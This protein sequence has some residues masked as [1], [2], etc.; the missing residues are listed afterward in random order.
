MVLADL[1]RRLSS[2]LRNLSNA[3][4]IN[5]QVLNEA[6]GEICRALLEA[7]VNVRLVKQLRENV[8]QAINLEETAV[9]LNK[10][11]LIQSAVV[12]E[13]VRLIDPEVKAWQPVKNK[14]NIVMFVG[15]QGSGKTTT[16][17][18]Y[19][20]HFMRRGWKTALVC[21]DT[22][23]AGAFDQ[24]K[25]NATKAR[26]PFY[27]SYTESDPLVIAMDGVETFRKDNFE[28]IVVDTSGRHAQE[29]SLFEEMLQISNGIQPD[30][31]IFVM[32]ASIGQACELQAQAF[33]SKVDVGS[34]IVTKLDSHAKGGGALSAVAAT[35]SPIIFIGT[36]EH[37]DDFEVFKTK[38]FISKLLGMG[39]IQGLVEKV[40]DLKLE[41][42][43]ELIEKL[44]HGQFTLRDMYEQFQNIMKM[45]P[46]GQIMGM[47]PGFGTEFISKSG[48]QESQ[49]RLKKMMCVMDSMNDN[50]LDHLDG[51]KL[52]K[53]QP[54]RY[55][56]VARGAGVSIRDVQDLIAQYSKF[57]Q[58]VKKMGGIK[59][60]FKSGDMTKN[61]NPTQMQKLNS[62]MS[63]LIDPRI[64]HQIGGTSGL[65]S[66]MRQFQQGGGPGGLVGFSIGLLIRICWQKNRI[67]Q[68]LK[69]RKHWKM[70]LQLLF[71]S[72]IYLIIGLPLTL[73][74]LLSVCG[75][76][77]YVASVVIEYTQFLNY[78]TILLCPIAS[79]ATLPQLRNGR[80]NMLR[81]RHRDRAI[82][83]IT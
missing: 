27:G 73:M 34:V 37:I 59:G 17:T 6:L 78:C 76:S 55:A 10:R 53:N 60:L 28:L 75:V 15:L 25:Q 8:K 38:P 18:K 2:A 21:A 50:E 12:K 31:I 79:V 41:D 40:N 58:M 33:K 70:T 54:G 56:R 61:V 20:Y 16:C 83:P 30:N 49:A 35:K 42:N 51:A 22:F 62:Q 7:D 57:A 67:G 1:G 65:S 77:S 24:L 71:V 68:S 63:K 74:H 72:I 3:T 11:R 66:M 52:F 36:G 80:K 43:E 39:D 14:S 69:W 44:K 4:I 9:G 45:G 81:L 46:F 32:D 19:A 5:E 13:L 82:A 29:E 23:R 64:L 26:I 47:I 48:E